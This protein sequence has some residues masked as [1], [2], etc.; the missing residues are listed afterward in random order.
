[1]IDEEKLALVIAHPIGKL[2]GALDDLL[3]R[4]YSQRRP[5]GEL[6]QEGPWPYTGA[7]SK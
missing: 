4:A 2:H 7:L 5:R 3:H 6:L 1:M